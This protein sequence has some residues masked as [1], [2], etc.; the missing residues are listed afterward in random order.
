M[1]YTGFIKENKA[2]LGATKIGVYNSNGE[3]IGKINLPNT[4]KMPS[5]LG[6]KL[7]SFGVV[8]DIHLQAGSSNETFTN[9]LNYFNNNVDF[10]CISGDLTANGNEG[11]FAQVK[12]QIDTY[13]TIPVYVISGNHDCYND[14]ING[15]VEN[16][17]STY[18]G[19]SLYYKIEKENDVFIFV[20]YKTKVRG[21]VFTTEEL[22]WLYDTLEEN[23]NKRCFLIQHSIV[24][25]NENG[26]ANNIYNGS[27]LIGNE[28]TII[29]S[30]VSHY[31]NIIHFHGHSHL[32]YELQEVDDNKDCN[33]SNKYGSHAIHVPSLRSPRTINSTNDGYINYSGSEGCVVDVYSKYIIV[34]GRDFANSKFLPIAYYC[35]DTS[36]KTID[37]Y[38]YIDSTGTINTSSTYSITN[39]LSNATN[40]N[41][42]TSITK[43][44]SYSA[45][46][47]P[48]TNYN[49]QSITVTMG[50]IDITSSCVTGNTIS[51]T[52]VTGDV[53]IT[54]TTVA[55]V[56]TYNITNN[57]SNAT[58]SNSATSI[59]ENT[60]YN[61]TI[62]PSSGIYSIDT[63][64]VIM[65]GVDVSST[66][67]SGGAINIPSVTGDI[68]ITATTKAFTPNYTFSYNN[69]TNKLTTVANTPITKTYIPTTP[70][71]SL[72]ERSPGYF[73]KS[74]N[75][76][77]VTKS[78]FAIKA[79]INV[80]NYHFSF[81]VIGSDSTSFRGL[82]T[83]DGTTFGNNVRESSTYNVVRADF[84]DVDHEVEIICNQGNYLMKIDGTSHECNVW[85]STPKYGMIQ[86][87]VT[88]YEAVNGV[89]VSGSSSVTPSLNYP[90]ITM[91][92]DSNY[93]YI[94]ELS[95]AEWD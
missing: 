27:M 49:I 57:L 26:D 95:F 8:S 68:V 90:C 34:K 92:S 33:Y 86:S 42:S 4:F 61:A 43:K 66:V 88:Y 81:G 20:G 80:H 75:F 65:N 5:D 67:V 14:G 59:E 69:S 76:I 40:S 70:T 71:S 78:N 79:K 73:N 64:T 41:N 1:S 17:L 13:A 60:S 47:T 82:S 56:K 25:N 89:G 51:I 35:I 74:L 10:V 39:N 11:E 6:T 15:A 19:S 94:K 58:N 28:L 7:Y 36:L 45:T 84:Q 23:R 24:E 48:S 37:A 21:S 63:I 32:I 54:V 50:G 16:M 55:T 44:A 29:K 53:V 72:G 87:N 2:P 12:S 3:K 62:T 31:Q 38:T 83:Y 91:S 77:E 9:A 93:F 85:E 22:Q 46:I 30:L 52:S 18:L